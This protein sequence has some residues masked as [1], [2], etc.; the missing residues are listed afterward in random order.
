M[1]DGKISSQAQSSKPS[2]KNARKRAQN[3]IS[4]QC[5]RERDSAK[6]RHLQN[7]LAA[8]QSASSLNNKDQYSILLQAYLE[9]VDENES[10]RETVLGFRK[11]FLSLSNAAA[12]AAEDPI[13]EKLLKK[14]NK[15]V[16]HSMLLPEKLVDAESD[17]PIA[18]ADAA[19]TQSRVQMADKNSRNT[20]S[21]SAGRLLFDPAMAS[22]SDPT[23]GFDHNIRALDNSMA[24]TQEP[25]ISLSCLPSF[26]SHEIYVYSPNEFADKVLSACRHYLNNEMQAEPAGLACSS[27]E[28]QNEL[29]SQQVAAAAIRFLSR[30]AGIELY[31]YHTGRADYLEK[32]VQWR[33]SMIPDDGAAIPKPFAPTRLQHRQNAGAVPH[34]LLVDFICWP[35]IRDQVAL[36]ATSLNLDELQRDIVRNTVFEAPQYGVAF[37]VFDV[38]NAGILSQYQL[39]YEQ[40]STY[41]R[42]MEW[43]FFKAIG[44]ETHSGNK[45]DPVEAAILQELKFIIQQQSA[46]SL[47]GLSMLELELGMNQVLNEPFPT[48]NATWCGWPV[49]NDTAAANMELGSDAE[50][51]LAAQN[52]SLWKVSKTFAEKYPMI[53]CSSVSN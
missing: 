6:A 45:Y 40:S 50:N 31:V 43:I 17:T 25:L 41:V 38:L 15:N 8:I 42:N 19:I 12:T 18:D 52:P 47:H 36:Y 20:T 13:F 7:S 48:R 16:D 3:R 34:H 2:S 44:K 37:H 30:A 10:L 39:D 46:V 33:L 51:V 1:S 26:N 28:I 14:R 11:R 5:R 24:F 27:I 35:E 29:L 22:S 49:G 32:I 21:L 53:D 4:Q 9:L 23:V